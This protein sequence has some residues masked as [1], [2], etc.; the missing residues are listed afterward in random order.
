MRSY[1]RRVDALEYH[2][3]SQVSA[4]FWT[5]GDVASV[6]EDIVVCVCSVSPRQIAIVRLANSLEGP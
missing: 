4:I 2:G 6:M 3:Q 1:A 5:A